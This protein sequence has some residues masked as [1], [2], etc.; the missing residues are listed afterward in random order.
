VLGELARQADL[1]R[2]VLG[3]DLADIA[4]LGLGEPGEERAPAPLAR[5]AHS[6]TAPNPVPCLPKEG[7]VLVLLTPVRGPPE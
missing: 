1:P 3:E 4:P 6:V 2:V 7:R 5:S